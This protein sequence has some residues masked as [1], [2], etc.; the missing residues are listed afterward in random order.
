MIEVYDLAGADSLRFSPF[1][2]RTK[3]AL[4]YK[5]LDYTTLPIRFCD[6]DKL[7]FSKQDRVPVI[8]DNDT[9][10]SDS[11]KIAEYL[12]DHYPE[13]KLFPGPGMKEACRFFNL[14]I[15]N[16]LHPALFPVL[17]H[18]IFEKIEPVDRD[19][20]R[21]NRE[22]RLG[23]TLEDIATRRDD[24]RPRLKS[25]LADLEAVALGHEYLFEVFTYADVCLFGSFTFAMR[26]SDEPLFDATPS[27]ARWWERMQ[28]RFDV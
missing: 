20:F 14:Y 4:R 1:C 13:A 27:L 22:A 15:D 12:E 18:D 23:A 6:K 24:F 17:V 26:V 8:R 2:S 21:E 25:V 10:V 9:V 19:Y 3:A 7:A 28:A 16:T 5:G 11:W